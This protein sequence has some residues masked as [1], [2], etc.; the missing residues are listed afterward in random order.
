MVGQLLQIALDVAWSKRR[1]TP[2]EQRVYGVPRQKRAVET[3]SQ[4]GFVAVFREHRRHA[5]Y[6]PRCRSAHVYGTLRILEV[7]EIGRVVLRTAALS[8][9][10]LCEF[11]R[12]RDV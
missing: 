4:S 6:D 12:E 8:G 3:T 1:T 2:C 5:R 11:T 9:N 10:E 7:V